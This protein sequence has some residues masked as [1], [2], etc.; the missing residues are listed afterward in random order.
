MAKTKISKVAKDLNISV[1]TV[2][3]FLRSKSIEVEDNINAR[4]DDHAVDLLM[5]EF[6]RDKD[7]KKQ[8]ADLFSSARKKEPEPATPAP[9]E[10]IKLAA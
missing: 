9:V 10:E 7:L 8:S 6:R 2:V 1:G 4:I 5:G 3:D